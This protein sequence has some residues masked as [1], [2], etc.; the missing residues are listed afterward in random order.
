MPSGS[1]RRPAARTVLGDGEADRVA[2]AGWFLAGAQY[3]HQ[4]EVAV[5]VCFAAGAAA[6]EDDLLR[7][8]AL[9]D[10][11]GDGFDGV[12]VE[13]VFDDAHWLLDRHLGFGVASG[14]GVHVGKDKGFGAVVAEGGL[15]LALDDGEGG[16]DVGGVV[17]G[18][19]VAVEVEGVE[20]G[21]EMAALLFVWG[22][23]VNPS[24][25]PVRR[26][27]GLQLLLEAPFVLWRAL[28][29]RPSDV[30]RRVGDRLWHHPHARAATFACCY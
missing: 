1:G 13:R 11:L 19:A 9:D 3:D 14:E 18:G 27:L 25:G 30:L 28:Q 24:L 29:E 26:A 20:V 10:E 4:V 8:E 2:L 16:E 15:V 12:P 21:P 7:L 5:L 17:F 23:I 22:L 6:E